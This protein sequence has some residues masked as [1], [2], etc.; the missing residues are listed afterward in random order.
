MASRRLSG[1]RE[2]GHGSCPRRPPV[3]LYAYEGS[4]DVRV[5]AACQLQRRNAARRPTVKAPGLKRSADRRPGRVARLGTV[6]VVTVVATSGA[7]VLLMSIVAISRLKPTSDATKVVSCKGNESRDGCRLGQ[8]ILVLP[9]GERLES[10]WR[11]T[12]QQKPRTG[13][14]ERQAR[15]GGIRPIR[16]WVAGRRRV[17]E[18]VVGPGDV[19]TRS[20]ERAEAVAS[21]K[22]SGALPGR[23]AW[24]VWSTYFPKTL[25]PVPDS[26]WNI[27][28]QWA[29]TRPD[30]CHPN[31][32]LH[33]N[34]R[35]K[36]AKLRLSVRG[37]RLDPDTCGRET[38]R[39][40]DFTPLQYNQ[41]HE[42]ILHVR[43]SADPTRGVVELMVNGETVVPPTRLATLYRGQAAY[44]KQG[45]YRA[46]SQAVSHIYHGEVRRFGRSRRGAR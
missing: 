16:K 37:G 7:L 17:T 19:P 6:R 9:G 30:D 15:R 35:H 8:S 44:L 4:L 13:W 26:T 41:W 33:V 42:F 25:R 1:Y 32:S 12:F 31:V 11:G 3:G 34:T 22:D 18:F 21:T 2:Q 39:S 29:G 23:E 36:P 27:F 28:T 45:L 46:P 43:W 10:R 20:G 38:D 40:W 5:A 24:Y 14:V